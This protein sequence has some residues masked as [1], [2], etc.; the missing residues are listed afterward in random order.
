MM[1]LELINS[2]GDGEARAAF[3]KCCG[4]SRWAA[5]MAARRP[6]A[7]EADLLAV[8]DQ[9]WQGL[10]RAD[11]LEA[12]AAHLRIGDLESLRR[13]YAPTAG[14]AAGEQAGVAGAS[15]AVLQ[16]LAQGNADYETKFGYRFI[17][18]A[19]GKTAEE[20][21]AALCQRLPNDPERELRLAAGEQAQ[22]TRLRL[23]KLGP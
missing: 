1:N 20:M 10:D 19:T 5:E 16:G 23:H 14:W 21:L 18:C 6:F 15:E 12:F 3:Q 2:W 17:I 8:A 4:S 9:V 13:R 7:G 11:W 22:I